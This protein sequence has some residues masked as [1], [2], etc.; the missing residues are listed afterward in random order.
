MESKLP[1]QDLTPVELEM[2]RVIW[3]LSGTN[4]TV[5]TRMICDAIPLRKGKRSALSTVSTY[6]QRLVLKGY[7]R[8]EPTEVREFNHVARVTKDQVRD[9][10]IT[11][12][13]RLFDS[14]SEMVEKF[15]GQGNLSAEARKKLEDL[16]RG[17]R[18]DNR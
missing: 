6:L 15:V 10:M 8:R 12:I 9:R 14:D 4:Q 13:K 7:V 2:M 11:K 16:T 1:E 17:K 3:E 5:T 18:P